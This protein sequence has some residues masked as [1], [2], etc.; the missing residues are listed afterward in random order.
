MNKLSG[1]NF[2]DLDDFTRAEIVL[3]LETTRDLKLE[4]KR[5]HFH[6]YLPHKALGCIF[7]QPSTRTRISFE[8]GMQQ[9]GG[10]VTYLKPGEIH[11]GKKESIYD[12]AK[13]LSRYFDA[14]MIRWNDYNEMKQLADASDVPVINGMTEKNHP[15][16]ALADIYTM[17]EKFDDIRGKKVVFFG[18]R[19]QPAHSLGVICSKLGLNFV[20]CCPEK[21]AILSDYSEI[22]ERNNLISGG[23]YKHTADIDEA[24]AGAHLVYTD[25]WWWIGQEE[26]EAERRKLF[27]PYQV[28]AELL[29]K[30]DKNVIFEHCLPAMRGVEVTDAVMD[31]PHAVIYDQA[32]N[33][34]HTEKAVM[35][36]L[37][38]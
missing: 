7:D 26:E 14:I 21:Y 20:H 13:V 4:V 5:G 34:M 30:C 22:Y 3:I 29:S 19:T 8:L 9:L 12:T 28:T 36:L 17:M 23:T 37:M 35:V 16:Q 32:E 24:C 27:A 15:C 11:L 18:D 2:M 6:P 31:G 25:V 10:Y 1:R 33:R 38:S